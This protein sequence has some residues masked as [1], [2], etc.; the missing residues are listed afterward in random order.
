[1]PFTTPSPKRRLQRCPDFYLSLTYAHSG[2][3]LAERVLCQ[4]GSRTD[5]GHLFG[6]LDRAETFDQFRCCPDSALRQAAYALSI[7]HTQ[8][9]RLDA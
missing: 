7:A 6:R 2:K 3:D 4:L 8:R 5:R 9:M 1:M